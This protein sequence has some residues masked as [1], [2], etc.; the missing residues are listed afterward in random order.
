MSATAQSQIEMPEPPGRLATWIRQ[1]VES[2]V[3]AQKILLDLT[4]QQNALAIGILRERVRLPRFQPRSML[5]SIADQSVSGITGAG[6]I[7]LDLA[8]GETAV[9]TD[10]LKDLFQLGP[11]TSAVADVIRYRA[12]TFIEMQ[13]KLLDGVAG[14]MHSVAES[15]HDGKGLAGGASAGELARQALKGFVD[16]ERKF[17]DLISGEINTL[18]EGG[19]PARKVPRDRSRVL[20]QLARDAVG[21]YIDAQKKLLDL[22][23][24]QFETGTRAANQR[25]EA[26]RA[27]SREAT[28]Q[29]RTS[30]TEL[31]QK[32]AKNLIAAERSLLDV[33]MKPAK[34]SA[35]AAAR[36]RKSPNR[37]RRK[38]N[39]AKRASASE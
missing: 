30:L 26:A 9:V 37:P 17:L 27:A 23:I 1:G 6:R 24:Q 32:S 28:E 39:V 21:Q 16:T 15:Y 34:A 8:A 31:A 33:A 35:T 36:R 20:A 22:T 25:T 3:A 7:L 19:K 18:S 13:R 14:Q 29:A 11:G 5:M 4:A 12:E 38:Q 10:G 2:F